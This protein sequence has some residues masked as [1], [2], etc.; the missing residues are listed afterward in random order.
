MLA[1]TVTFLLP[2]Y[3]LAHFLRECV[4]SIVDQSYK[5]IEILI[6]DDQSP[7]DAK[8]VSQAIIADYPDV[9]ITYVLNERNLGNIRNYNNGIRLAQGKYVW[10]VSPDDRLRSRDVLARYVDWM[11][12]DAEIG[13]VFC[14]ANM[15]EVDRDAGLIAESMY[16]EHDGVLDSVQ[17]V[18]DIVSSRID[19]VAPSVMIRKT[20]YEEIGYFPEDMPHRGDSYVW[21][22]IA[23][24]R[25]VAF[26]AAPMVDYRVHPQSMMSI[27]SDRNMMVMMRDDIATPWRI[28]ALAEANNI[29]ELV[30]YCRNAVVLA[31][32]RLLIGAQYRGNRGAITLERFEESLAEWEPDADRRSAIRASLARQ[33]YWYA[34][35][36]LCRGRP[37][38]AREFFRM[39]FLL[40]PALRFAPPF[41]QLLK[42][43]GLA[44]R[45]GS[46]VKR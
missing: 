34:A 7:D 20:C 14:A 35:A 37:G 3:R 2:C 41:G 8:S 45:L 29:Q 10:I 27:L 43:P 44:R 9:R 19:I 11:E 4:A 21:A 36:E 28:E 40:D 38:T 30:D 31:Y 32:K 17:L 46:L 16:R 1:P 5:D 42:T 15:I 12:R 25:K 26:F 6:L 23:M 18:K 13:Y 33:L 22:A 24:R 39:T